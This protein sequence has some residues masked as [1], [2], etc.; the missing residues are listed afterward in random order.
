MRPPDDHDFEIMARTIF[1]EARGEP[2]TG[3]IAVAHVII[4]R[5]RSGKWFAAPSLAGVCVKR[6]QFSCWN[7]S[8]PTYR[9]LITA[10][11]TELAPFEAIARH[12]VANPDEDPTYGATHY[13]ADTIPAPG[14]ATGKSPTV[15]IGH[16]LF[17]KGIA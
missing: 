17:F 1:G 8:D 2:V 6:L 4:N 3:Q 9:R 12:A 13:Y 11:T 7:S 16:H 5:W 15:Q 14:W 10:S